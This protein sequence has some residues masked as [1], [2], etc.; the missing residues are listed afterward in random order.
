MRR[1]LRSPIAALVS[2]ALIATLIR[3]AYV[4]AHV[5]LSSAAESLAAVCWAW[6]VVI[7]MDY[8]AIRLRRRPC[9]DFGLFLVLTFPLSIVW[10]CLWSRGWR[11]MKL[12]LGL[13]AL[14]FVP[15]F[16]AAFLREVLR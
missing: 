12:L 2:F 3:C 14:L 10:Y 7:W 11:G 1:L 15:P 6:P 16:A 4:L 9:F 8:D 13:V 5:P